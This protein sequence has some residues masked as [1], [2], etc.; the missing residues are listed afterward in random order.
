MTRWKHSSKTLKLFGV[1]EVHN[2]T[3]GWHLSVQSYILVYRIQ[4]STF[5]DAPHFAFA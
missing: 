4:V 5:F 2:Q 1:D 3:L